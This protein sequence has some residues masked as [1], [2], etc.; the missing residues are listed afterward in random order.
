MAEQ[1]IRHSQ[2]IRS[3]SYRPR[4]TWRVS[5]IITVCCFVLCPSFV[6]IKYCAIIKGVPPT[7]L[8][9]RNT[10]CQHSSQEVTASAPTVFLHENG[11]DHD[12]GRENAQ[13]DPSTF[14]AVHSVGERN[15]G[16]RLIVRHNARAANRTH[17]MGESFFFMCR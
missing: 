15:V 4:T 17:G 16:G 7:S 9:A 2:R 5:E 13:Q 6:L 3:P 14:T 12:I 8:T 11:H 1:P 10:H